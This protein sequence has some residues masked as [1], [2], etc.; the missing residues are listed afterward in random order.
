MY[1]GGAVLLPPAPSPPPLGGSLQLTGG[2][3]GGIP[4]SKGILKEV[5]VARD[6]LGGRATPKE[7]KKSVRMLFPCDTVTPI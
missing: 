2:P 6:L 5:E 1:G 7:E 3:P 4:K